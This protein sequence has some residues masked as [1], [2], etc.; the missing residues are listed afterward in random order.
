M[1]LLSKSQASCDGGLKSF[2][3][4]N[5]QSQILERIVHNHAHYKR[6]MEQ[7]DKIYLS[8]SSSEI[9]LLQLSDNVAILDIPGCEF[10]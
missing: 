9:F 5:H 8:L 10:I 6:P 2:L 7:L 3:K 1:A 4:V